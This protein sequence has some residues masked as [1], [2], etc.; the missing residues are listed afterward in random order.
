MGALPLGQLEVVAQ[1]HALETALLGPRPARYADTSMV[2]A[3]PAID[4]RASQP[5]EDDERAF[6]RA[7]AQGLADDAAGRVMSTET[8]KA[9]L[10]RKLGPIA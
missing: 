3:E 4:E 5:D 9:E 10:E 6:L 1:S 8:L 7:V 2:P